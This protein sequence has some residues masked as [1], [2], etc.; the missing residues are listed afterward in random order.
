MIACLLRAP[1]CAAHVTAAWLA[2]LGVALAEQGRHV[3]AAWG[4]VADPVDL[5]VYVDMAEV[6][7]DR[8][9]LVF[10]GVLAEALSAEAYHAPPDALGRIYA[11]I[12]TV[13][14]DLPGVADAASHERTESLVN[15]GAGDGVWIPLPGG[16]AQLREACD[17]LQGVADVV[18][19]FALAAWALPS[20]FDA[21]AAG[22]YDSAGVLVAPFSRVGG[23]SG[24]YRILRDA[25][26]RT[27]ADPPEAAA[28]AGMRGRRI[29]SG[30]GCG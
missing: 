14:V 30:G 3:A 17:P 16:G 25:S 12:D 4:L 21:T 13:D 29:L 27:V 11:P 24:D 20:Y 19:G 7:R 15:P 2:A 5:R 18:Q 1:D 23:V 8:L 22:P 26:G 6:P 10:R 9:V 28:T